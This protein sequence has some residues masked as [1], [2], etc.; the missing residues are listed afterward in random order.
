M[1][2]IQYLNDGNEISRDAALDHV[3]ISAF[4]KG[5]ELGEMDDIFE[6]AEAPD[7]EEFRDELL[8]FGIEVI[9][10]G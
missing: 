5:M 4:W 10:L 7:G 6:A 3:R 1:A 2:K 8:D 9:I